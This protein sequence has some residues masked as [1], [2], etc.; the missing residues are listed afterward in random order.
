MTTLFFF[1]LTVYRRQWHILLIAMALTT[2]FVVRNQWT[3][4]SLIQEQPVTGLVRVYADTIVVSGDQ[5][6]FDGELLRQKTKFRYRVKNKAEQQHWQNRS[7]KHVEFMATG[8]FT[9][10]LPATNQ[11]GFDY[12]RYLMS[13]HYQ[14]VVIITDM[15]HTHKLHYLTLFSHYLRMRAIA[16]VEKHLPHTA[17]LWI[18]GLLFNYRQTEYYESLSQFTNNGLLHLFSI[19]GMHVYFFLGW[20]DFFFRRSGF[21]ATRQLPFFVV[22]SLLLVSLFGGSI[23]ILR[24][25]CAYLLYWSVREFALQLSGTDRYAI[26]LLL[27]LIIEPQTLWQLSAQLSF[28]FSFFLLFIPMKT[29]TIKQK[30]WTAQLFPLLSIPMLLYHFFD[31]PLASGIWTLLLVPYFEL[32]LL[33]GAVFVFLIAGVEPISHILANS[34]TLSMHM[35]SQIIACIPLIKWHAGTIPFFVAVSCTIG[36]LWAITTKHYSYF[37]VCC[38][39]IPFGV[40]LVHPFE[41]ITFLD[42]GQGDSIVIQSQYNREVY[43]ID[44]GGRLPFQTDNWRQ[45][46][47]KANAEYSLIPYLKGEGIHVITGLFLTHGDTDHMGDAAKILKEFQVKTV[48]LGSGSQTHSNIKRLIKQ[49]PKQNFQVV[50]VNQVIGKELP[51]QVLAPKN[52]GKGENND[53]LVL[54]T[55]VAGKRVLLTGD[56]EKSGELELIK[57][58]PNLLVDVLKVGHHGSKTA[59]DPLFLDK[60]KPIEAIVSVGRENRYHHPHQETLDTLQDAHIKILRTDQLG[61][62]QYRKWRTIS[63]QIHWLDD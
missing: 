9:T 26:I 44:T 17:A 4:V 6:T 13:E 1:S 47:K 38:V 2:I 30:L 11:H 58:Y 7:Q 56:L 61:M 63:Q 59:T 27:C 40:T 29:N 34:L 23:S 18:N 31:W 57:R 41:K 49:F 52:V 25:V 60:I 50:T 5:V 55:T 36:M 12:R 39:L 21:T 43:L 35:I 45:Q 48:Y 33:P 22:F 53:S 51:L 37:V 16:H 54:Y 28:L 10:P 62:I 8:T 20:L 32:I 15:K 19:S 42:I 24:A 14:G 3:T 46:T